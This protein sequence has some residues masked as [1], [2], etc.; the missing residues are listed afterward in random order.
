MRNDRKTTT[1]TK[2]KL[3]STDIRATHHISVKYIT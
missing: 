3:L 2:K 1:K